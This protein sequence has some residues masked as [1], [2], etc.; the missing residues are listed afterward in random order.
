MAVVKPPYRFIDFTDFTVTTHPQ[1]VDGITQAKIV[2]TGTQKMLM[3]KWV[4]AI[5]LLSLAFV[6]FT[7]SETLG[8]SLL[9]TSEH[10]VPA[11]C[12]FDA[13]CICFFPQ[14]AG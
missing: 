11:R 5:L 3:M 13:Y 2:D 9:E 10:E 14:W 7:V 8:R 4:G 12:I 6:D 1:Q